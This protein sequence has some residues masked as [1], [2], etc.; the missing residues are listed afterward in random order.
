M[1]NNHVKDWAHLYSYFPFT[2]I[3]FDSIS[4]NCVQLCSLSDCVQCEFFLLWSDC[5]RNN[6]LHFL[7]IF[8]T[9]VHCW[10]VESVFSCDV[11]FIF[12][13]RIVFLSCKKNCL[14][15]LFSSRMHHTHKKWNYTSN[16]KG[17]ENLVHG[18][19]LLWKNMLH[20]CY[21]FWQWNY[22]IIPICNHVKSTKHMGGT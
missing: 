13:F 21:C 8:Y 4:G 2:W 5:I 3:F 16:N 6:V 7:S 9:C 10:W 22:A 17:Q 14:L 1:P 11:T 12:T 15:F 20:V 19:K 18:V